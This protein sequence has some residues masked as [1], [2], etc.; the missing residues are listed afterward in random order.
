LKHLRDPRLRDVL[1]AASRAA[2]WEARASPRPSGSGKGIAPGRG[3]A[4]VQYEG[5]NGYC[6]MVAEVEGDQDEGAADVKRLGIAL[7]CRPVSNPDGLRNQ[8]EGGALQGLSRALGEEVTWDD[9]RVTSVDWRSYR[10]LALGDA[11][12]VVETVLVDRPDA[13][14]TGAGETSI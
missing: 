14:A 11:A 2:G 3:V 4:C 10:S 1:T 13:P 5:D 9:Q 7:D 6:A 8:L 12:P